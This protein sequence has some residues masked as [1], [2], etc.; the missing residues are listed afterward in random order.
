MLTLISLCF[1]F[2][3]LCIGVYNFYRQ[4]LYKKE[5]VL[6]IIASAVINKD[7]LQIQL[8]YN[9]RGNLS[10]TIS[11]V[12]IQLDTQETS[13]NIDISNHNARSILSDTFTLT[14]R[15]SKSITVYYPLPDFNNLDINKIKIWIL[16]DYIDN[17][18]DLHYDK[19]D[20]GSLFSSS[21]ASI[22]TLINHQSKKL[23]GNITLIS[24]ELALPAE[25]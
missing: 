12:S 20:V 14:E 11:N 4:H 16:T 24:A 18:N 15:Q 13:F 5:E 17:K 7:T 19:Y 6:L 3:A 25:E 1:S 23:S 9:N 2:L 21:T 10:N 8:V 22:A